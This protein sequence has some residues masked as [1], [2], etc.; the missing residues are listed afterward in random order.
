MVSNLEEGTAPY[1]TCHY[2][3]GI[4]FIKAV[5]TIQSPQYD[6]GTNPNP[7]ERDTEDVSDNGDDTDGTTENDLVGDQMVFQICWI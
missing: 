7:A 6:L 4:R 3:K 2:S 1:C 5:F